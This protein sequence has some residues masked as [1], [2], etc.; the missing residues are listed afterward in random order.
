MH[1]RS[2]STSNKITSKG[3]QSASQTCDFEAKNAKKN[4]GEGAQPPPQTSPQW[5]E[6][7]SLPT[8]HP[9]RRHDLNPSHSEILPTLLAVTFSVKC[10][11]PLKL[12]PLS[13]NIFGMWLASYFFIYSRT[14]NNNVIFN[15]KSYLL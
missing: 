5:G 7:H 8:P 9:P 14:F 11:H 15:G 3:C 12:Y 10:F 6:G 2:F 1:C 13:G 4:S